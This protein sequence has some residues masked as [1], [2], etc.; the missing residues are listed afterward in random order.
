MLPLELQARSVVG[1]WVGRLLVVVD[2]E[3]LVGFCCFFVH[4]LF[5]GYFLLLPF[6]F[7][8]LFSLAD[9]KQKPTFFHSTV[10]LKEK[11]G[12]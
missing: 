3:W 6:F 10:E 8:V 9:V 11:I 5:G 2:F 7:F 12:E 4:V 1:R